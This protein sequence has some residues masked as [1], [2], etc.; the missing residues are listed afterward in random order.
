MNFELWNT[1]L[2]I[3]ILER[4]LRSNNLLNTEKDRKMRR[5]EKEREKDRHIDRQTRQDM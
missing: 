4:L 1:N 2:I 5:I 3:K